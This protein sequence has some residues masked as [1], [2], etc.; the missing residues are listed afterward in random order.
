[1]PRSFHLDLLWSPGVSWGSPGAHLGLMG[2]PGAPGASWDSFGL[3][4][5][6]MGL[7]GAHLSLL[8]PP[9]AHLGLLGSPGAYLGLLYTK[10]MVLRAE[11]S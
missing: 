3:P 4:R 1:M 6:L 7:P 5:D 10:R 11:R 8:G 2:S 9:G